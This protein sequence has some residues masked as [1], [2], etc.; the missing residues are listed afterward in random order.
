MSEKSCTGCWWDYI[1]ADGNH[2]CYYYCHQRETLDACHHFHAKG[3]NPPGFR[4]MPR[5]AEEWQDHILDNMDR[6]HK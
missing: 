6:G 2:Y 5:Q 1:K 3:T 4:P